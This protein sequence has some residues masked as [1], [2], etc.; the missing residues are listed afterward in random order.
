MTNTIGKLQL[1][2]I[3]YL[4]SY[5]V[6]TT[7]AYCQDKANKIEL[8]TNDKGE[9][10]YEKIRFVDSSLTKSELINRAKVWLKKIEGIDKYG[11]GIELSGNKIVTI[12][13][14]GYISFTQSNRNG[15]KFLNKVPVRF[16]FTIKKGKYR[17]RLSDFGRTEVFVLNSWSSDWTLEKLYSYYKNDKGRKNIIKAKIE[18]FDSS[19]KE[20]F[21]QLHLF[22]S[23]NPD[24]EDF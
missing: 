2:I 7:K 14:A 19:I 12:T 11:Q 9:I 21:A 16:Q 13:G 4:F 23:E 18:G 5:S 24:E 3:F 8:L 6:F 1:F 22:M 10:F 20:L 17:L 15:S